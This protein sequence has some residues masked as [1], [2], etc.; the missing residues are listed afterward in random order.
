M[1]PA[2]VSTGLLILAVVTAFGTSPIQAGEPAPALKSALQQDFNLGKSRDSATQC[3]DMVTTLTT[4]EPDGRRGETESF[5]VKL[6][7]VPLADAAGAAYQYTC[8]RFVYVKPDGTQVSVTALDGWT[9]TFRKTKTGLD[10]KG[11]VFG[12]DHSKF[13]QLADGKGGTLGPDKSYMVYNTFIDFHAFCDEFASP[14]AEGKGIQNLTRIGQTIVHAAAN[15]TPP[16]SLVGLI[17]DKTGLFESGFYAISLACIL[18]I[19]F[20]LF[21]EKM[22]RDPPAS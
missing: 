22:R 14:V 12:I 16:T 20:T 7:C 17:K 9:Y 8:K 15:T 11:Q 13:Q 21:L 6:K 2:D 1:K 18:G 19:V 4:I 3:F 10:D 5:R